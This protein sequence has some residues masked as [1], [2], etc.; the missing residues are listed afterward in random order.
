MIRINAIP[1][2]NNQVGF[3]GKFNKTQELTK[4]LH[5]A[6]EADVK[7]FEKTL[8]KMST[9]N[10]G[11]EWSLTSK[12]VGSKVLVYLN[13]AKRCADG[14]F[15]KSNMALSSSAPDAA[16]NDVISKLNRIFE[17]HYPVQ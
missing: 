12:N 17:R 1:N 7:K 9:V 10:D 8:E 16:Y 4:A 3:N 13:K 6:C 2:Y 11:M 5:S 14:T 15:M